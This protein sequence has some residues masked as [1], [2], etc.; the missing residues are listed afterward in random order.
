MSNIASIHRVSVGAPNWEN[1]PKHGFTSSEDFLRAV[2]KAGVSGVVDQRLMPLWAAAGSDEHGTYS[3]PFGG[4][5][6]P[7]V[8]A[9]M[10]LGIATEDPTV[11]TPVPMGS[12]IVGVP[13]RN[14]KDHATSVSGGLVMYRRPETTVV[15]TS[16]MTLEQNVLYTKSLVGLSFVSDILL[17]D[18]PQSVAAI[19]FRSYTDERNATILREK[20]SGTGVGEYN[21]VIGAGC[22][23]E[24]AKESSQAAGSI[25]SENLEEMESRCWHYDRAIWLCHPDHKKGLKRLTRA[26]GTGGSVVPY[27]T[28]APDGQPLL[29]GRP[30]FFTDQ[31]SAR[32]SVG[33]IICG[34]WSE[35]IEGIYQ[36][37]ET[38]SSI[39][40]RF[41]ERET[42]FRFVERGDGM[43]WWRVPLTQRNSSI[44]VSPFVTLAARA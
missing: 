10:T 30:I 17:S 26:I 36:P 9:P 43:P 31:C 32:G 1:D 6:I 14:D 40:V 20:I 3:D 22:T 13:S 5:L 7:K 33:D 41:A 18:S 12:S 28:Y 16:R 19:L 42:A 34:V 8:L 25:L 38:A 39:H 24:V 4:F 2:Q 21:G 37:L 15:S 29:S 35:F 23:I 44:T 11:T 27:L